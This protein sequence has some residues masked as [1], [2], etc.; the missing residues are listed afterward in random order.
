MIGWLLRKLGWEQKLRRK[1]IE[2]LQEIDEHKRRARTRKMIAK[3]ER[4]RRNNK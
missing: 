4:D 2:M 3:A 1:L